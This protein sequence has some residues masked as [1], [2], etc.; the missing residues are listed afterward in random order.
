MVARLE[1]R[2]G[3]RED[4]SYQMSSLFHGVLMELLPEEYAEQLHISKLHPYTQHLELRTGE[5]FWI[6]TALNEESIQKIIVSI[7]MSVKKIT[8]KKH[9]LEID[10]LDKK[11]QELSD[12]EIAFS[13][14]QQQAKKYISIQFV[15]PTAFKQNGKY[16]NYPDIRSLYLNLMNKYD[17]VSEQESMRDEETLD[18]LVENTTISRYELRST[19]FCLEGVRIP[20]FLGRLTLRLDGAQTMANFADVLLQFGT[21][22]GIGIKTALGMGAIRLLEER[23]RSDE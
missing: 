8:V 13:F 4:I 1:M 12:R 19:V 17:A 3:K 20:A 6:V 18:Q 15:T 11:Y 7:L 9:Q 16:L 23:S 14:Y 10:I 22:S 21:Y 5:W 2:L